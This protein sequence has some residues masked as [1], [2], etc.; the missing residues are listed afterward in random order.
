MNRLVLPMK[1]SCARISHFLLVDLLMIL[2]GWTCWIGTYPPGCGLPE[3]WSP[4]CERGS[5]HEV[6]VYRWA[7]FH[8]ELWLVF[9][10][11]AVA[12]A[13]MVMKVQERERAMGRYNFRRE[14]DSDSSSGERMKLSRK[15]STQ[16]FL[17]IFFFFLTWIFPMVQFVV[18][19]QTGYLLFPLLVLTTIINPLQGLYD[20]II[21]A[22]P[23]YLQHQ[24]RERM[25]VRRSM[26]IGLPSRVESL[27]HCLT[28]DDDEDVVGE[29]MPEDRL[30]IR[31]LNL[32]DTSQEVT[33]TTGC[34]KADGNTVTF[35][36]TSKHSE[37]CLDTTPSNEQYPDPDLP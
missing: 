33:L 35:A 28:T 34:D 12:L 6:D 21:Y 2:Q 32:R 22:R 31:T 13:I 15:V 5:I 29:T 1:S 7:L 19:N 10:V 9:I 16:A 27:V 37:A 23:R 25:S 18:Q 20:A 14:N 8:A 24:E 4:P 26:L 36:E 11:C 3:P 17:Y 30:S